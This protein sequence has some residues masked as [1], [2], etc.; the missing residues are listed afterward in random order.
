MERMSGI[1]F[2][3]NISL[4]QKHFDFSQKNITFA[5]RNPNYLPPCPKGGVNGKNK[6][7]K[8]II[9]LINN[10]PF[11]TKECISTSFYLGR[12]G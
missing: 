7:Y 9:F 5:S 8:S 3:H 4:T 12:F 11:W 10:Q 6:H 1:F 2:A